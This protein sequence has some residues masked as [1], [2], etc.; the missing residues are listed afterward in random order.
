[1]NLHELM[2]YMK[3]PCKGKKKKETL[4]AVY[5][6]QEC[7]LQISEAKTGWVTFLELVFD[8]LNRNG[9]TY[10][11]YLG[12]ALRSPREELDSWEERSGIP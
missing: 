1:M 12:N 11:G 9:Y 8:N 10:P 6:E 2:F 7:Q 5:K 4:I 3:P